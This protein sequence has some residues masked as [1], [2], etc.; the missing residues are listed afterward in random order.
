M[1]DY[2][3]PKKA[4]HLHDENDLQDDSR[5]GEGQC[6]KGVHKCG[7]KTWRLRVKANGKCNLIATYSSLAEANKA[8]VI[9]HKILTTNKDNWEIAKELT[10][11][12]TNWKLKSTWR[13]NRIIHKIA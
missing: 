12:K 4:H 9:F 3:D 8:S 13:K 7:I 10:K 5:R 2:S 11:E 6:R 1:G